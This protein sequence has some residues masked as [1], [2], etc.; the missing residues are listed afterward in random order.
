MNVDEARCLHDSRKPQLPSPATSAKKGATNFILNNAK[1]VS[2]APRKYT[3]KRVVDSH[4][5]NSSPLQ[6]PMYVYK[7]VNCTHAN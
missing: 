7:K 5:G 3:K 1:N 2:A 4:K 6:Q